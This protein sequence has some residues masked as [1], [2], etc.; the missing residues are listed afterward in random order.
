MSS[1]SPEVK[2]KREGNKP[3]YM[4]LEH[5]RPS[6][7]LSEVG[8]RKHMT[9]GIQRSLPISLHRTPQTNTL[10]LHFGLLDG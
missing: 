2:E 3:T 5:P 4:M 7:D 8:T 6:C 10:H 1:E 9:F